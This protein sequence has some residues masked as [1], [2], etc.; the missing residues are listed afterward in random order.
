MFLLDFIISLVIEAFL[1]L[2]FV[3]FSKIPK[4]KGQINLQRVKEGLSNKGA[5][6]IKVKYLKYQ[7]WGL[8]TYSLSFENQDGVAC[9]TEFM[10]PKH[11]IYAIEWTTPPKDMF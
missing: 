8:R 5:K 3:P 4:S 10:I 2:I 9:V 6:N 11:D 7:K 1:D